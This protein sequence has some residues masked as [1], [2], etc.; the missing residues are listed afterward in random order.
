MGGS[1]VFMRGEEP[2]D[3]HALAL[4]FSQTC[5]PSTAVSLPVLPLTFLT[6]I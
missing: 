6:L 4:D 3:D 5:P 2:G 1:P